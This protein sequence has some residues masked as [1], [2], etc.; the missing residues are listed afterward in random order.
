MT[1]HQ[2]LEQAIQKAIDSGWLTT[3][4]GTLTQWGVREDEY[5]NDLYVQTRMANV[6][7][8]RYSVPDIIFNHDFA[9]ALWGEVEYSPYYGDF[10]A[11]TTPDMLWE[12][13]L[14]QMV[15]SPDPIKYLGENI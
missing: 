14:Q 11:V 13:H 5:T 8:G 10:E 7:S 9:K 1:N 12:W 4:A 2:I 3:L 15:I 6:N